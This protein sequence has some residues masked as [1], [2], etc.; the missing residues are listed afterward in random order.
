VQGNKS[1]HRPTQRRLVAPRPGEHRD[2]QQAPGQ[3]PP[4]RQYRLIRRE[5]Q[6]LRGYSQ[7]G[8]HDQSLRPASLL[9]LK[10]A[11]A[12]RS[13]RLLGAT[14]RTSTVGAW[15][16]PAVGL[17]ILR[18]AGAGPIEGASEWRAKLIGTLSAAISVRIV[19]PWSLSS[20]YLEWGK[21]ETK[22]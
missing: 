15:C 14:G 9:L 10:R 20:L 21:E 12:G 8:C 13:C 4:A 17:I 11:S 3:P 1:G 16:G 5:T 22:L 7:R 6:L 18:T 19:P 2:D